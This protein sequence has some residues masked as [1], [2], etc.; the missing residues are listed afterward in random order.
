MHKF[1]W[2]QARI[3]HLGRISAHVDA[4]Q[5]AWVTLHE[6]TCALTIEHC[7]AHV[8]VRHSCIPM[9]QP[10][11]RGDTVRVLAQQWEFAWTVLV[12]T[13]SSGGCSMFIYISQCVG[14]QHRLI[15]L[16]V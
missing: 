1:G 9:Y 15:H 16:K 6:G 4:F 2:Y 11:V 14:K 7:Q 8:W 3:A 10:L 13:Q 12:Q 5:N